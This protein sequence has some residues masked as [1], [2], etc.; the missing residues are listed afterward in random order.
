[1]KKSLPIIISGAALATTLLLTGCSTGGAPS[2][3][4][5]PAA[6]SSAPKATPKASTTAKFGEVYKY[7]DGVTVSVSAPAPFTPGQYAAGATQAQNIA[8]TFTIVN[9]SSKNLDPLV[10][11]SVSSAGTE[12][13]EIT[14]IGN[15]AVA[16][17]APT[18]V[19]LPNGTATWTE[20][21]SVADQTKLVVELS[22][23]F[24]YKNAIF[25]NTQ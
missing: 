21:F 9:G 18:T 16:A 15:D 24:A 10:S 12:A 4:A 2:G 17:F 19:I 25:T 11:P 5:A 7:D 14:D 6:A 8:L 23:S 22:P 13:A 1:M 20:A 3:E